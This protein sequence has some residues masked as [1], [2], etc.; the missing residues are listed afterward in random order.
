MTKIPPRILKAS[1]FSEELNYAINYAKEYEE[2]YE[3]YKICIAVASVNYFQVKKIS[4]L[5]NICILDESTNIDDNRIFISDLEQTK[6]YEFNVVIVLNCEKNIFPDE[7][8]PR[9]E[10]HREAS[11]L[12]VAMTRA[13]HEL[14]ISYHSELS[15][16][17][18]DKISNFNSMDWKEYDKNEIFN[19][20]IIREILNQSLKKEL[21]ITGKE[22]LRS[23]YSVGLDL[24]LQKKIEKTIT[25]KKQRNRDGIL[26]WDT[27]NDL[28][29]E[30]D[31]KSVNRIFGEKDYKKLNEHLARKARI[32]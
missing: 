21:N 10:W 28:L 7:D 30:V 4:E 13:K 19:D 26:T 32:I 6:G 9:G 27:I 22:F 15:D 5:S 20:D 17:I 2:I 3:E 23:R 14:I 12:Y 18:K 24:E 11:K 29:K 8:L 25:G 16:I 1:C 31:K